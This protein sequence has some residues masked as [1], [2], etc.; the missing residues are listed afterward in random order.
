MD[1]INYKGMQILFSDYRRLSGQ[2]FTDEING[3]E[4][5]TIRWGKQRNGNLLILTDITGATPNSNVLAAFRKTVKEISPYVLA[6]A[7]VG[8][9]GIKKHMLNFINITSPF[10]SRAFDN[11]E[12]AK[13]W[14]LRQAGGNKS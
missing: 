14:L 1:F 10:K 12:V 7:V 4:L 9:D 6:S 8:V 13:E 5:E 2:E 11:E 3:R